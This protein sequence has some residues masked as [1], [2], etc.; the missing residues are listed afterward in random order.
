LKKFLV[1]VVIL[2]I[3]V[4][5]GGWYAKQKVS[6]IISSQVTREISSPEGQ[7]AVQKILANPKVQSELKKYAGSAAAKPFQSQQDAINYAVSKL[8]PGEVA[9]MASDYTH[10]DSLTA[11]QKTQ[12]ETEVLSKFSPQQLASMASTFEK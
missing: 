1:F 8:S 4:V 9:Q 11:A 3:V 10:R 12:I 6:Q 2:A 5:G 7:R